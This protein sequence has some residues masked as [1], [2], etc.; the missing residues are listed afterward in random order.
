MWVSVILLGIFQTILMIPL[1]IMSL[2]QSAHIKD[3]EEEMEKLKNEKEPYLIFKQKVRQGN[4]ALLFYS[5]NFFIQVISF[6]S[7][8]KLFLTDFYNQ[9]IN[10][11]LLYSF[12]PYPQYP[13]QSIYFKLP[14][15]GPT[16]LV[17]FGLGALLIVWLAI[18]VYKVIATRLLSDDQKLGTYLKTVIE[19]TAHNSILLILVS[20]LLI[21]YFPAAWQFK[22]FSGDISRPNVTFNTITAIATFATIFWLNIP[23]IEKKIKLAKLSSIPEKI[24]EKTQN[25]LFKES[26]RNAVLI[27]LGAFFIT[28]QIPCAFELSIF[29]LEVI[30]WLSP[31]TLDKLILSTVK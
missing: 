25:D 26:L 31:F 12:V 27:G 17:D 6:F 15:L 29:T 21:R 23:T 13:I 28:N 8:G 9:K 18:I 20:W 24:I 22:V 4:P 5:V 7:M 11:K 2:K 19:F 10:A 1:R 3:F 16:K 30:S 14:Y